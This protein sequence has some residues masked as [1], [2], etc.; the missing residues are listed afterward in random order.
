VDPVI[1]KKAIGNEDVIDCRPA[2]LLNPEMNNLRSQINDLADSEEDV[3]IYAMF[4]E[5]GKEYLQQRKD[6]K[7]VP[8]PLEPMNANGGSSGAAPVEFN[9]T[10]HGENYHIKLTGSGYQSGAVKPFYL[11]VD[12]VPEEILVETLDEM[13]DEQGAAVASVGHS[14]KRPKATKPGHVTASMPGTIIDILVNIGDTVKAGDTVLVTEAMKMET[15]VHCAT[16][17]KV[18]A[19]H[20]EKGDSVNPDEA[21]I[22]I[23]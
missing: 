20:V 19:I 7:L 8:E 9:I 13:M 15:E 16:G 6:N 2:D 10:M 4:P 12:G 17:G 21:L 3:L 14:G 23:E 5:V 1:L 22:E 11:T 18:T